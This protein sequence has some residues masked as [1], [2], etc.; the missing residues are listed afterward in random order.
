MLK[1]MNRINIFS[2]GGLQ[3]IVKWYA[4]TNLSFD[5][6]FSTKTNEISQYELMYLRT[7]QLKLLL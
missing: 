1:V 7:M 3:T 5:D 6:F 4:D 2:L